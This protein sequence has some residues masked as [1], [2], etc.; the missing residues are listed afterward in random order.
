MHQVFGKA[1]IVLLKISSFLVISEKFAYK[2][3]VK[4][5]RVVLVARF[6][7]W[8]SAGIIWPAGRM[9][10]M[11]APNSQIK[12]NFGR[13]SC[14][15]PLNFD[16]VFNNQ[17]LFWSREW[18]FHTGWPVFP[19]SICLVVLC[20]PFLVL[21]KPEHW[22]TIQQFNKS[23]IYMKYKKTLLLEWPLRKTIIVISPTI[24]IFWHAIWLQ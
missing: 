7:V 12:I 22:R 8:L 1:K 16:N 24:Q 23:Q 21:R 5:T 9:L 4:L 15:L 14:K 6:C 19:L 18:L 2:M 10:C 13:T 11:T 20:F 17:P 3:L